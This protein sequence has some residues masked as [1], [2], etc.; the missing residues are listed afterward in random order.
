VQHKANL[1]TGSWSNLGGLI[2]A[3]STTT[4]ATDNV[5]TNTRRFYQILQTN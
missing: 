1:A 3:N 5:G 4:T 2:N